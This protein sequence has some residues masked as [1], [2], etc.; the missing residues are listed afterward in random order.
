MYNKISKFDVILIILILLIM[1]IIYFCVMF[2]NKEEPI[3]REFNEVEE[4]NT[5]FMVV[6]KVNEFLGLINENDYQSVYNLLDSNYIEKNN[7]TPTNINNY[8]TNYGS[9]ITFK[10][11]DITYTKIEKNIV[12]YASGSLR[13]E[14]YDGPYTIVDNE[15][16]ILVFL[17]INNMTYSL[18]LLENESYE[19]IVN[20]IKEFNIIPNDYNK[21]E[22]ASMITTEM[23][24]TVYLNDFI[25]TMSNSV[26][27]SYQ[28]INEDTKKEKFNTLDLYKEYINI[29]FSKFST[30]PDKCGVTG[31]GQR[32][33][34]IYDQNQNYYEFT[35]DKIM[36]Y[37]VRFKLYDEEQ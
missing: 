16:D 34:A 31:M 27:S 12:Y 20:N 35:E 25:E 23:M 8:I 13:K 22:G 29:N 30:V 21:Y 14:D 17:D 7:I 33:Y 37:Y 36:K 9:D 6:D 15:F 4:Y 24:C 2:F 10:T 1:G 32:V 18:Y 3:E 5:Y 28:I 26:D 19:E 11:T